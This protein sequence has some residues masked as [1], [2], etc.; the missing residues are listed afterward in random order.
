MIIQSNYIDC[1]N[2]N[3]EYRIHY[4]GYGIQDKLD[5]TLIC[6]HGL[7]RN[8]QDYEYVAKFFVELG[9]YVIAP[10]LIGHGNSDY[11][12]MPKAYSVE[13]CARDVMQ[14]IIKLGLKNISFIGTSLGGMVGMG[15]SALPNSPINKLVLNDIGAEI[16]QQGLFRI[17]SSYTDIQPEYDSYDAIYQDLYNYSQ[18]IGALP[19]NVWDKYIS[20]SVQK[21]SN[22]KYV[23]KKDVN[24]VRSFDSTDK[25]SSFSLWNYWSQIKIPTL[26]IRG[27]ESDI[28]NPNTLNKMGQMHSLMQTV[29]IN[30][31]GHAPLLYSDEHLAF[32]KQFIIG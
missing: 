29:E 27:S 5:K 18:G 3:E 2:E 13:A 31:A 19:S 12:K 15:L 22:G 8:N 26:V 25:S 10:D 7:G 32:L 9:Y 20:S 1:S 23:I 17:A 21:N 6:V 11:L 14:L 4:T 16:D 24:L 30:G 28:L